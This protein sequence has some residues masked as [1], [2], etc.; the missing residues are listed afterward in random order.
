MKAAEVYALLKPDLGPWFKSA[1]FQ[2]AE[3]FLSWCRSRGDAYTV[4]WCQVSRD[5]WDAYAGSKF[6]V[7]FQRSVEP[8]PGAMQSRSARLADLL[9]HDALVEL[10]S[11]QNTVIAGL[12]APPDS[13]AALHVSDLATQRYRKKFVLDAEPYSDRDD[14]WL[15]YATP[16]HVRAWSRFILARLPA[17]VA[18]VESWA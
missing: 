11:L 12:V 3:G 17:C 16:D 15:R 18:T 6:V 10:R 9:Q 4:V 8:V 2:R 14:V 1:G 13:H 5:S 7:T